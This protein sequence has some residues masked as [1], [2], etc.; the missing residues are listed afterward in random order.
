MHEKLRNEVSNAKIVQINFYKTK[1]PLKIKILT[2]VV[3]HQI[4]LF[5]NQTI[6]LFENLSHIF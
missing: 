3:V 2:T 5:S 6:K 4:D 1:K